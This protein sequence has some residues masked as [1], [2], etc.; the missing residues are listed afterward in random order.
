MNH[1]LNA[2]LLSRDSISTVNRILSTN[3]IV[4]DHQFLDGLIKSG[5]DVTSQL[6]QQQQFNYV[7]PECPAVE[8][9]NPSP[10]IHHE[11]ETFEYENQTEVPSHEPAYCYVY[12]VSQR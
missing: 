5:F 12:Q 3:F 6:N 11:G 8:N 2:I 9:L 4:S 7:A 1:G 10:I